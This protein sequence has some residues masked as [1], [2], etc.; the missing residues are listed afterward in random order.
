MTASVAAD[1]SG[2]SGWA[3]ERGAAGWLPAFTYSAGVYLVIRVAL[4]LLSAAAWETC[5]LDGRFCG[6]GSEDEAWGW[7]LETLLGPPWRSPALLWH[8]WH[9]HAQPGARRA[10]NPESE[11][12]WRAY[13]RARGNPRL[14][15]GVISGVVEAKVVHSPPVVYTAPRGTLINALPGRGVRFLDGTYTTGDG[16]LVEVLDR[17]PRCE[18]L[19]RE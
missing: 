1:R 5:P 2:S 17:D 11:R 13:R 19:D 12:L 10:V 15:R 16:D 18:R 7:A 4:F 8:L 6:W 14:M 3:S 9:P